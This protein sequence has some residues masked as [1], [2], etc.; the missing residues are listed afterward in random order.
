MKTGQFT[1][2]NRNLTMRPPRPAVYIGA[3]ILLTAAIL[4]TG[5]FTFAAV[6]NNLRQEKQADL[7]AIALLK[8]NQIASW[9]AERREE[10][11]LMASDTENNEVFERWL[12]QGAS[13][14][15]DRQHLLR[16]LASSEQAA[17]YRNI[18][19]I[20]PDGNVRLHTGADHP[21]LDETQR[22]LALGTMKA[23]KVQ[24]SRLL[25]PEK[26]RPSSL[27]FVA[28]MIADL[29]RPR[30][31][32]ALILQL[33]P[34]RFLFPLVQLWPVPSQSAETVLLQ[35]DGKQVTHLSRQRKRKDN[36]DSLKTPVRPDNPAWLA[37]Q[38]NSG[39][40]EGRDYSGTPVV[41]AVYPIP[42]TPWHMVSKIDSE[43][44]YASISRIAYISLALTLGFLCAALGLGILWWRQG[45]MAYA[46]L[47]ARGERERQALA[48]H[49]ASMVQN[50]NDIVLLMNQDG[51]IIEANAR[52]EQI[53][54][55]TREQLLTLNIRDLRTTASRDKLDSQW[56]EVEA[57]DGLVFETEHQRQDGSSFPVEVSARSIDIDGERYH[58]DFIR[59]I[60]ERREAQR[61]V[62]AGRLQV[63]HAR[64]E[65]ETVFDAVSDPIFL[66]D[67]EFRI[68]R[69]NL[70]YARTAG[71]DIHEIIGQAYWKIFPQL[72]G[73]LDSCLNARHLER[74]DQE[75]F[76][77]GERSYVSRS[78]PIH[79]QKATGFSVHILEDVTER[80]RAQTLLQRSMKAMATLSA[81]NT[82]LVHAADEQSLLDEMCRIIVE[83]GSYRL[84]W[85]GYA[86]DDAEKSIRPMAQAGFEQGYLDAVQISWAD[87]P[88]GRG[89]GGQALRSGRTSIARD[90]L[91]DPGFEPWREDAV[92]R[93]YAA[94]TCLPL[95]EGEQVFGVL[96]IYSGSTDAFTGEEIRLLEEMAGDLAFGILTLRNDLKRQDAENARSKTLERLRQAMEDTIG[97]IAATLERRDPYTAGHQRRVAQ[98]GV[99]IAKELGLPTADIEGIHFGGLIHDLGKIAVPAEILSKPGKLTDI[100]FSL[101]KAHAQTGYEIVKEVDFPWPV[102]EMVHQ[103]HERLDGSGYPQGLKGEAIILNARIL[104]VADVVEAMSSHRPYR[105]SLGVDTALA[106]IEKNR[107]KFYD[108]EITDACVRLFREKG[109]S[110]E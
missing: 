102:A 94:C 80:K 46:L 29:V 100:E 10:T 49:Y 52:A 84:A 72:D 91:T 66:H 55:Y 30:I 7:S 13:N 31:V 45:T 69:A 62:E 71:K 97:I 108:P 42:G 32:G 61:L 83:T 85:V 81:G 43:E 95:K 57:R 34:E 76:E 74:E 44:I 38:G 59:D 51:R 37:V 25:H 99:A 106:E 8:T 22:Q 9:I 12:A 105:P 15:M 79:D 14:D 63:E 60:S 21:V 68:I 11:R 77:A 93:G 65:W 4:A 56:R 6:R 53:Y 17:E 33:D 92:A 107:G 54:G 28:P 23:G 64:H 82:A 101:I 35:V 3:F 40:M 16:R 110:F 39:V 90:I 26:T 20:D 75:G 70:A 89:P 78:F 98:L 87:T 67:A 48:A 50:A 109:F 47:K 86:Q 103:H 18:I 19:L 104:A 27:Y 73:P 24:I 88:R 58:Q 96:C 1:E 2:K 5:Y 36:L 41:A